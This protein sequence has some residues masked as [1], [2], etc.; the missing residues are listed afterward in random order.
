MLRPP[1]CCG[2]CDLHQTHI[3]RA[4]SPQWVSCCERSLTGGSAPH[5]AICLHTSRGT[6][7]QINTL[8][9]ESPS[10]SRRWRS[11]LSLV[12]QGLLDLTGYSPICASCRKHSDTQ[13]LQLLLKAEEHFWN[14]SIYRCTLN[15]LEL[16]RRVAH[17]Y[18]T[19]PFTSSSLSKGN[20]V[21]FPQLYFLKT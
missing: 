21:I 14:H 12:H 10:P 20:R 9:S 8:R 2:S 13:D 1:G 3:C 6:F 16:V 5:A 11:F 19:A 18:F 17:V 7:P 4:P 15:R